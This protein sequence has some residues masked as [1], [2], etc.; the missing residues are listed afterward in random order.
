MDSVTHSST[1]AKPDKLRAQLEREGVLGTALWA[2]NWAMWKTRFYY[3]L[4]PPLAEE[5]QARYRFTRRVKK[6]NI[7][8]PIIVYQMGKVG[9]SSMYWS[10]DALRLNVPVYHLHFLNDADRIAAWAKK[11]L[12]VHDR[13]LKMVALAQKLRQEIDRGTAPR[14]HLISLVR[15]PVPRNLSTFFHNIDSYLPHFDERL[16]APSFSFQDVTDY[17]V[18]EFQ[19]HTPERWF[20]HQVRDVFGLDVYAAPFARERGYQI[21]ENDR[22]RLLVIRLEDLNRVAAK[23]MS[24]F[25]N[26]PDFRLVPMNAGESKKYGALYKEYLNQLRLPRAYITETNDTQY[27]QHFYTPQELEASV[28]RWR[29][30]NANGGAQP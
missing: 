13:E 21:Y 5:V 25:L 9:S 3:A 2:V 7:R 11:T 12:R 19:E 26:I 8:Q 10:L 23:A 22:A 27:A 17:F 14:Y 28:A 20:D 30:L 24:E 18:N 6:Y 15:A 1:V 4:P 29:D 16:Q